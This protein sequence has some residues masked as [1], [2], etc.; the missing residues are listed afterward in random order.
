[1][2]FTLVGIIIA[3][4]LID[5]VMYGS[6]WVERTVYAHMEH[7]IWTPPKEGETVAHAQRRTMI[8]STAI[9]IYSALLFT[10]FGEWMGLGA[11]A[12][13]SALG[14][15]FLVWAAFVVP[16]VFLDRLYFRVG[17]RYAL[18]QLTSWLC[19]IAIATIIF[20]V[21]V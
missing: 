9:T 12:I 6:R 18:L 11:L 8:A 4:S 16:F 2:I 19:K 1:M 15:T 13:K 17:T 10:I 7:V 3:W 21:R 14:V 5:W 20:S